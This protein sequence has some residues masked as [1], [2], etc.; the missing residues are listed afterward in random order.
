M[1]KQIIEKINFE[2]SQIDTLLQK[3]EILA[4]KCAMQTPDF[5]EL[6]AVGATL[7][8]YYN[9]LENIFV[10]IRKNIDNTPFST[11]RWHKELLDS[12]FVKTEKRKAVLDE[13]I[14]EELLDYMSFRHVFRHSYGYAL[15][16]ARLSPL[17][18]GVNE[19]WKT[20]K[21]KIQNFI[22]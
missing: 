20:V 13:N 11:Q 4:T 14:H 10:L 19:N 16:W 5:I 12:M 21:A 15:D 7:H 6:S 22:S 8:S 18:Y 3:A 2:I 1:D 9:G 17:F